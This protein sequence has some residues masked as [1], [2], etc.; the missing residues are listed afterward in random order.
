M[1]KK[2]RVD[3]SLWN[4]S[5]V[6]CNVIL[7]L[8]DGVL[9]HDF[10]EELLTYTTLPRDEDSRIRRSNLHGCADGLEQF[11]GVTYNS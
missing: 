9:M 2:L 3:R 4:G 8:T 5:A 7:V 1:P 11:W 10:G 6:D